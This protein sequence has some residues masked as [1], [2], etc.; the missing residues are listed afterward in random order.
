MGLFLR[1]F[2]QSVS[3]A[4]YCKSRVIFIYD[5]EI[6]LKDVNTDFTTND[7]YENRFRSYGKMLKYV[8]VV[9]IL[10]RIYNQDFISRDVYFNN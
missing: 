1:H 7:I 2:S 8:K 6:I 5:C 3:V 10:K 4:W 9:K